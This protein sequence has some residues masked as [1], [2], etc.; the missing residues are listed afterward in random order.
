M[1]L[2]GTLILSYYREKST[3]ESS[4]SDRLDAIFLKNATPL[5]YIGLLVAVLHFLFQ[6]VLFL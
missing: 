6:R 3:V 5:A 2:G 1:I 4:I